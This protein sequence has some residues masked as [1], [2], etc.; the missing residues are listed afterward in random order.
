MQSTRESKVACTSGGKRLQEDQSWELFAPWGRTACCT[1]LSTDLDVWEG[2]AVGAAPAV[3]HGFEL[4]QQAYSGTDQ[5]QLSCLF[6]VALQMG[7]EGLL[8]QDET[9]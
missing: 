2:D 9:A 5:W 3:K 1:V 6:S 7:N 4:L 8:A